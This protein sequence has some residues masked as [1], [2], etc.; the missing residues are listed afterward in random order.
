MIPDSLGQGFQEEAMAKLQPEHMKALV[1]RQI[2]NAVLPR[3]QT[4]MEARVRLSCP[5]STCVLTGKS[6]I[7]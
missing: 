5:M 6:H 2:L 4:T 7:K 1:K 3:P